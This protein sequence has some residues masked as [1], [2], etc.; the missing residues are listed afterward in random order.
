[1]KKN[2]RHLSLIAGLVL[3][4]I[5]SHAATQTFDT[6][7]Q[8]PQPYTDVRTYLPAAVGGYM[9][10]LR[11]INT[12]Q[13]A[14]PISVALI[15][16]GTGTVG[17][18]GLLAQSLPPGTATFFS[19]QQVE[20][21]LGGALSAGSRPRIRVIPSQAASIEVQSFLLQPGGVFNEVSPT[22]SGSSIIVTTY[23][24]AAAAPIGYA[25][26]LRI[27]NT[28]IS[29][30]PVT[31]ARIDPTTG[32]AGAAVTLI[33]S[34]AAGTASFYCNA[35]IESALGA[36]FPASDRP[37]LII[38]APG[39]S[40]DVQSFLLQPGGAY[41]DISSFQSGTTVDVR[42]YVPASAIGYTSILRIANNGS[43]AA[44]VTVAVLDDTTGIPGAT[45]TITSNLPG[46][47]VLMLTAP[48]LETALGFTIPAASRPRLRVSSANNLSVQSL[49]LQPSGA[50]DEMS[51]AQTG[52]SIDVRAYIPA[53]DG[54]TGYSSN[55]RII[56]TGATA[57]PV[58][59]AVIDPTVGTTGAAAT[60]I[61][62]L[63]A[64]AARNFSSSQLETAL[65]TSIAAGTRPRI[66]ISGNGTNVLEVQSFLIQPGGAFNEV[67]GAQ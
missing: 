56:N 49:L 43:N 16:E 1:M 53:A 15:D 54:V 7:P 60:L 38:S 37:Q 34:L 66:Q 32:Q 4:W 51:G 41:T 28:G 44:A 45:T 23:V 65:G 8:I 25:S 24:P 27:I 48:Q 20:T 6:P 9:T 29:A 58:T 18:Q 35:S 42:T 12:G 21:A 30:T 47:G 3:I 63:P 17:P 64:G 52:T 39:A 22:Q 31:V 46:N 33:S 67:S 57:T 59:V 2:W 36:L 13:V 62:S 50:Y 5:S 10:F 26:C 14:T 11:V 61:A 55:V 40:L 19:P